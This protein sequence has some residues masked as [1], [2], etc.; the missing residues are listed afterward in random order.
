MMLEFKPNPKFERWETLASTWIGG[1][2][3]GPQ[4]H[5]VGTVNQRRIRYSIFHFGP[6]WY[7]QIDDGSYEVFDRKRD[8][9]V[10]AQGH[11]ASRL[12][13]THQ[14]QR[15]RRLIHTTS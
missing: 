7:L 5:A 11:L 9:V 1:V 8:A 3:S 15:D 14:I 12:T 10:S 13:R 6:R 2:R 4:Y